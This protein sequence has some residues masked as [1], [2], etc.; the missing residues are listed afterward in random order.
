MSN[1][2]EVRID[3]SCFQ[4]WCNSIFRVNLTISLVSLSQQETTR[5]IVTSQK[6]VTMEYFLESRNLDKETKALLLKYDED[7]NGRFSKDEVVEIICDLKSAKQ[8]NDLLEASAKFYKRLVI[9]ACVFCILLL[10]GMFGLSYSVAVLT[11]NTFVKQ[12][13]IMST[14]NGEHCIATDSKANTY[15]KEKNDLGRYCLS[16]EEAETIKN[17]RGKRTKNKKI[18]GRTKSPQPA[19]LPYMKKLIQY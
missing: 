15:K 6:S 3:V 10:T 18:K 5:P 19:A 1:N 14:P 7:G 17:K 8:H 4:M 12:D 13:G 16:N 9:G 11:S 2:D